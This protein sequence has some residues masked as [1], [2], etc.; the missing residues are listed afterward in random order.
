M[1]RG[2]Q[3]HDRISQLTYDQLL[4]FISVL[5]DHLFQLYLERSAKAV[6][7]RLSSHDGKQP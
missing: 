5:L 1:L 4:S 2:E 6:L 3:L 7:V